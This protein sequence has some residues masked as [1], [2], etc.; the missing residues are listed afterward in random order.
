VTVSEPRINHSKLTRLLE[1]R[2][3]TKKQNHYHFFGTHIS[4]PINFSKLPFKMDYSTP[5]ASPFAANRTSIATAIEQSFDECDMIGLLEDLKFHQTAKG[6]PHT[7]SP[8]RQK[9]SPKITANRGVGGRIRDSFQR[10]T[11]KE[12]RFSAGSRESTPLAGEFSDDL[13]DTFRS[14]LLQ[15]NREEASSK[16]DK[17]DGNDDSSCLTLSWM[18]NSEIV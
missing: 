3:L 17:V 18:S 1:K 13:D 11:I 16:V 14:M 5:Q 12:Q 10:K 4:H 7:K 9:G 2:K 15:E 6:S 8:S